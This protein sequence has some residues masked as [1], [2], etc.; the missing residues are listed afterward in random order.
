MRPKRQ[1]RSFIFL[2]AYVD[3]FATEP[4]ILLILILAILGH[5]ELGLV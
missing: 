2:T 4:F 1:L 5:Y 3:L